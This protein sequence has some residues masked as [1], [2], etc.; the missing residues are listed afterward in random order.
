VL[1]WVVVIVMLVLVTGLFR[2]R[3][4]RSLRFGRLPGDL[5]VSFRGRPY[6]FPFTST[7]LL[8]LVAWL[9]LRAI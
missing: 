1:K 9:I 6:R 2:E 8:S 3:L 5:R 4:S 7:L